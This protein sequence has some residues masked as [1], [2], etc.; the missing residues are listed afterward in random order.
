MA[1]FHYSLLPSQD[2]SEHLSKSWTFPYSERILKD[3]SREVVLLL[4]KGVKIE[5]KNY[6]IK[7]KLCG[8]SSF[9]MKK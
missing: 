5:K 1:Q 6:S 8:Q 9:E 3:H 2:N 4:Q 7:K